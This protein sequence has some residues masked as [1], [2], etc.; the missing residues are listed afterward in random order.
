MKINVYQA[1]AILLLVAGVLG[2]VT[3]A[4]NELLPAPA[5]PQYL[6]PF[7]DGLKYVF[8]TS[9]IAPFFVM[10]INVFGYFTNKVRDKQ[11]AYEAGKLA[12]TWL[13]YEGI[14]KGAA[15]FILVFLQSTSWSA[16]SYWIAG[17]IAFVLNLI[18]KTLLD[19]RG[20]E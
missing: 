17:S 12:E 18:T 14:F 20:K 4:V 7:I 9:A 5:Y 3:I 10:I 13:I 2:G 1:I 11:I 16:Y 19:L 6:W 8:T 15:P